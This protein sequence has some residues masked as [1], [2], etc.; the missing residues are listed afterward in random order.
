[1]ALA[2]IS[3]TDVHYLIIDELDYKACDQQPL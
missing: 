1:M 3:L 2:V